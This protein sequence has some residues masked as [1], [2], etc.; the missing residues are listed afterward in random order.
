MKEAKARKQTVEVNH[1]VTDKAWSPI[2]SEV[3]EGCLLIH[4]F[5]VLF[6]NPKA[7]KVYPVAALSSKPYQAKKCFFKQMTMSN[8]H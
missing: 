8:T 4:K 3:E 2:K 6:I 5:Y 7:V 1:V